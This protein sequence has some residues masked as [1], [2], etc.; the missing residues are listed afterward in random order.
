MNNKLIYL[1]CLSAALL[2]GSSQVSHA[3]S[4]QKDKNAEQQPALI[5]NDANPV[6]ASWLFNGAF[7]KKSFTGLNPNYRINQGDT[8]LVQLWGGLDFQKEITVDAQG[9]IFIPKVGPVK[10]LSVE[11]K[12]LNKVVLKSIKRVYK[13][14]VQAYVSLLS[15]QT[16]KVFLSGMVAQPGLYEGQSADSVLAFIDQAGGIRKQL[17]SYRNITIKRNGKTVNTIDLYD[18]IQKGILTNLQLHDGDVIFVAPKKAEITIKGEAGF[19]GKYELKNSSTNIQ[20][21]L[22]AV[23]IKQ[24]AT[25][26]TLIEPFFV[27]GKR[28]NSGK[29]EVQVKQYSLSQLKN[30]TVQA[31]STVKVS[32]QL[33]AKSISIE[34]VGEHDSQ[35]EMVLPWGANLAD[36]LAKVQYTKL[37]NTSAIQLYRQSVAKRQKDMLMTSLSAL[38]QS[39]LTARSSTKESAELRVAEAE[40][41]LQWIEKAKKI[42]PKGQVLLAD[43]YDASLVILQ[44]GDR[45]V[46]PSKQSLIMVHGEVLFPTAITYSDELS[47]NNYIAKAGGS[48]ADIDDMNVLIMKPNGSFI[49]VNSDLTDEDEIYPGDEIFVLAKPD[50]KSLQLTKDITQVLYQVAVSA[51]VVLAL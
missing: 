7:A 28:I 15:S 41:I 22:N 27:E 43:G 14:N 10:V 38:E 42:Q 19:N 39:V 6:F 23:A 24:N 49:D 12:N 48:T 16:V 26:I 2:I 37:S 1:V 44:Q 40:T 3:L 33:R 13:S 4:I 18:F 31:G 50:I 17:G 47:A 21:I 32:S 46:V 45:I 25:H 30:I 29:R 11:N 20:A 5:E 34:I 36:L 8:L 9:N 51:A 35:F